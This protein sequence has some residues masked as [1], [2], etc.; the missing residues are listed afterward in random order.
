MLCYA[1]YLGELVEHGNALGYGPRDFGLRSIRV[2]GEI[3][4]EGLLERARALFGDVEF[5]QGYA[6][7][8]LDPLSGMPC[9]EGHLHFQP[10]G[11]LLELES[12][13]RDGPPAPGEPGTIVATPFGPYRET[14]LLLRYDTQDVAYALHE[15]PGCELA[16]LPGI[17][18]PVGRLPLSVKHDGGWTF[19]RQVL[20]AVERFGEVPLPTRFGFWGEA[21]GVAVE[22]CTRADTPSLKDAIATAL[23]EQG[24]PLREL[25]LVDDPALV[26][27]PLPVRADLREVSFKQSAHQSSLAVLDSSLTK[28]ERK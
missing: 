11:G 25:R 2:G 23:E 6:T 26:Q 14:T 22:L 1:S 5:V 9:S 20:E 8:E 28:A 24:V 19:Q 3:V 18:R 12:L 7:N 17:T 21:G 16:H 15:S 4:T 27:R 13:E 10:A